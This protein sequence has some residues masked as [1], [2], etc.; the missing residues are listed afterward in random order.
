MAT[1]G[2]TAA[3]KASDRVV[4]LGA[5][6]TPSGLQ[7]AF[8]GALRDPTVELALWMAERETFVDVE[9]RPVAAPG[10]E[11][12]RRVTTIVGRDGARVAVLVHDPAIA[13]AAVVDAVCNAAGAALENARGQLELRRRL[14]EVTGSR[15]QILETAHELTEIDR[16]VRRVTLTGPGPANTIAGLLRGAPR[17]MLCTRRGPAASSSVSTRCLRGRNGSTR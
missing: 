7:A 14:E 4:E 8:C 15:A 3:P 9:G 5:R 2:R 1:S 12:E 6:L 10:R 17:A 16:G 13:D 11:G